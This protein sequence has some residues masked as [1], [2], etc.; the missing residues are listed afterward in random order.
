MA[1]VC[2]EIEREDKMLTEG[3]Y[4]LIFVSPESIMTNLRWREVLW[5]NVYQQ[6]LVVFAVDEAH[7]V[8]KW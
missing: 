8:P 7:C 6:H 4:H 2:G 3:K 5:S 1:F